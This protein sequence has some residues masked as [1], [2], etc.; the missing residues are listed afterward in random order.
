MPGRPRSQ[1]CKGPPLIFE[2]RL[3]TRTAGVP[4]GVVCPTRFPE[5]IRGM[6]L[7]SRFAL[8]AGGT[9]AVPVKRERAYAKRATRIKSEWPV[10]LSADCFLPSAFYSSIGLRVRTWTGSIAGPSLIV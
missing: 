9:P 4:P 1:Q 10:L 6:G 2:I 3:V 7:S 5:K 8:T